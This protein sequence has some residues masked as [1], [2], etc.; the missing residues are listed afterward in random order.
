MNPLGG[1]ELAYAELMKRMSDQHR[2]KINVILSTCKHE[3][4][5]SKKINI[6]WQQ[7]SYDQENVQNIGN[8]RFLEKIDAFVFVSHWQYEKFK[9]TF[10]ISGHKSIVIQ[11]ATNTFPIH[12]KSKSEKLKLIYTSMPYRGLNVLIDAIEKLDRDDIEVDVY[13]STI[14]YGSEF[15]KQNIDTWKILFDKMVKIPGMYQKGYA[16]NEEIRSA[17][18]NAHI[19]AYPSIFEETSCMSAIEAL[20]AGCKLVCTNLGALP[21]TGG[22]WADYVTFDNNHEKS[23]LRYSKLLNNAIETYWNDDV[24]EKIK[25]QI[26]F[27]NKYYSWDFRYKQWENLFNRVMEIKYGK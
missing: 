13:S 24:Q 21:E 7:L 2:D 1:S 27:Y 17:V 16:P 23:V 22:I 18:M 5:D 8:S 10:N 19:M 25:E 3:L 20:A 12:E 15:H 6:L 14:I 4:I 9:K 26:K 11:N